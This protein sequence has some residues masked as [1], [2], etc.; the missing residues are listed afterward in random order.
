MKHDRIE[1]V[2][3]DETITIH[4]EQTNTIDQDQ[5]TT[6][7]MGNQFIEVKLGNQ[8]TKIDLGKIETSAMQSIEL[9]VGPSSIKLDPTGITIKGLTIMVDASVQG[10]FKSLMTQVQGSAMTQVQ[11]GIVTIN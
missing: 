8:T 2:E 7:T 9:T 3:N 4:G 6:V 5:K 11:G 10:T 1:T